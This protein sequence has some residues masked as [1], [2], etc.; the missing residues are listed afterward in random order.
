MLQKEQRMRKRVFIDMDGV[1]C[2]YR[3]GVDVSEM[4]QAGYFAGLAPRRKMIDAV[5]YLIESGMADVFVLSSVL[6]GS[7][8]QATMEKNAW[9]D[10]FLPAV[11]WQHR[12]F[13]V[14]GTDKAA[15][16]G[17]SAGTDILCDDYSHNLRQWS[18]AGGTAIKILNEVNGKNGTFTAG[19][20]LR[21]DRR[22]DL[23]AV[24]MAV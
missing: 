21:I 9:L 24:V 15:A 8:S 18:S 19:P 13:P 1:L 3:T 16:V 11:D 17:A 12:I 5:N 22:E 7:R 6:P 23:A 2:E 20:R 4:E 14:C 10:R